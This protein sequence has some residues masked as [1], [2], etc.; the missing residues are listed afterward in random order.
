MEEMKKSFASLLY[1]Q[2]VLKLKS[3]KITYLDEALS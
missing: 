2:T 1:L 3:S